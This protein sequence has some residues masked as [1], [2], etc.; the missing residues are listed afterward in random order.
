MKPLDLVLSR[1]KERNASPK[2]QRSGAW[3]ARCPWHD[4]RTPSLSITE[5]RDGTV[6]VHCHAGCETHQVLTAL[7]LS[8]GDLFPR[9]DEFEEGRG[10]ATTDPESQGQQEKLRKLLVAAQASVA[11]GLPR[12]AEDL[13]EEVGV[14]QADLILLNG[15]ALSAWS[16]PVKSTKQTV[17]IP[18]RLVLPAYDAELNVVGLY[19][20]SRRSDPWKKPDGTST[21]KWNAGGSQNG[22]LGGHLLR[23]RHEAL[24]LLCAGGSDLLAAARHLPHIV[25]TSFLCGE[26]SVP[27]AAKSLLR[28]RKVVIA[29]DADPTGRTGAAKVA[30]ELASCA[31][32]VR[33]VEWPEAWTN[34][35]AAKDLRDFLRSHGAEAVAKVVEGAPLTPHSVDSVESVA[36]GDWKEPVPFEASLPDLPAFPAE[37]L[38]PGLREFCVALAEQAQVPADLAG[39][40]CLGAAS[41]GIAGRFLVAPW[42]GYVEQTN[43]YLAPT[44]PSGSRKSTVIEAALRPVYAAEHD[45]QRECAVRISK[46]LS[47]KRVAKR[48]LEDAE[49]EAAKKPDSTLLRE[50]AERLAAEHD[51]I[52]VLHQPR[53]VTT[54]A[55]SEAV[56]ML[57]YQND[58]RLLVASAEGGEVVA[59]AGGL[60]TQGR[61][62]Y[63]VLLKGWSGDPISVDRKGAE[64][65]HIERPAIAML[66]MFQPAVLSEMAAHKT[67]RGRGLLGR[68][69]FVISSGLVGYRRAR[70][71]PMPEEARRGYQDLIGNL[72]RFPVE[73]EWLEGDKEEPTGPVIPRSLS[74]SDGASRALAEFFDE[75]E[76]SQRDGGPLAHM[77]DW[78]SKGH[79]HVAR[80]AGVL[81]MVRHHEQSAPWEIPISEETVEGAIR[82][83]QY[84]LEHAKAAFA[85]MAEHPDTARALAILRHLGEKRVRK[86]TKREL[87]RALPS[88]FETA[89]LLDRPL[90]LLEGR[91]YIRLLEQQREPGRPGR[92]KSV[93]IL[94][95][96]GWLLR[97]NRHNRHNPPEEPAPRHSV[98]SVSASKPEASPPVPAE[99]ENREGTVRF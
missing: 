91:G 73:N 24:V 93:E 37:V 56:V 27:L 25:P 42:P 92:S 26:S 66:L 68:F 96:P 6:L 52:R 46:T 98:N 4:D 1:L 63:D 78:A 90:D 67:F 31:A 95:N 64:P 5:V 83:G 40:C 54:N 74:F 3:I 62:N 33:I 43:L 48:M 58:G 22:V 71:V 79:G 9:P 20:R 15:G 2:L 72:L 49:K 29:Y 23:E 75:I 39:A 65:I 10:A 84:F 85:L 81:H 89:D 17:T 50:K 13:L 59:I 8:M 61:D 51:A 41:V 57:L 21:N 28:G 60:Y 36:G 53:L 32:E 99:D 34:G 77:R 19:S 88:I 44:A 30:T 87:H 12:F 45:L 82:L 55:T 18:A 38:P 47:R 86:T 69:L 7:G 76:K 14:G 70:G 35:G 80:I 94:V 16:F 11:D 97:Q